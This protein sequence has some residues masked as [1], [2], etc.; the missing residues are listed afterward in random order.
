MKG[1]V[2]QTLI[3]A[4]WYR[5][6]TL[7]L[8]SIVSGGLALVLIQVGGELPFIL[9]TTWFFTGM[10]VFGCILPGSNVIN[11]RKKQTL[12]F[13]MS[14][15]LSISQFTAAKLVSTFGIFF[16]PWLML[17]G[18]AV[19]FVAGH[20]NIPHGVIPAVIILSTF[21][22]IGFCLN[23]GVA[24]V[25][26][27]E[28][29]MVAAMIATNSSYGFSWYMLVRN[30]AIRANMQGS[31]IVWSKEILTVLGT[32]FAVIVLILGLTFFLQSRKRDFV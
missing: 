32:E 31:G 18:T 6:R 4:D 13:L 15:P 28:G 9:G 22:L 16:V 1:S 8:M 25:S 2:V 3:I 23:A 14:L 7:I 29:A 30:P 27:S 24:L 20:K 11:E 17:V 5:H 12:P 26:E 10:I 19:A 21:T